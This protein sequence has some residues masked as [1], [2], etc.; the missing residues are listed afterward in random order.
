M[1]RLAH[2]NRLNGKTIASAHVYFSIV[3]HLSAILPY[4]KRIFLISDRKSV[5]EKMTRTYSAL[6]FEYIEVGNTRTQCHPLPDQ[7]VFLQ[8]I[9][10]ALPDDKRGCLC[11]TGAG[12]WAEIYCT[13]VKQRG[14]VGVDIGSGF[15]LLDGASTRPVHKRIA[16]KELARYRL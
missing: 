12:P 16:G 1:L 11:L 10:A 4:A 6:Q 2:E 13:W 8:N 9:Y 5:F 3:K 7:P 14:G 15:D